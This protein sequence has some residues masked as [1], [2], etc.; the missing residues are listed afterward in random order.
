MSE[1][2]QTVQ[3]PEA[4]TQTDDAGAETQSET[5]VGSEQPTE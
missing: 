2:N 4:P 1:E 3:E 5:D